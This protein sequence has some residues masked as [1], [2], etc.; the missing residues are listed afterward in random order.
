MILIILYVHF[1]FQANV[2][3][4]KGRF[5]HLMCFVGTLNTKEQWQRETSFKKFLM[6]V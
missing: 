1:V 3:I 6:A 5:G 2:R 4:A